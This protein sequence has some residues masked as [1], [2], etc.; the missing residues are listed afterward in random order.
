MAPS[1]SP[2][3]VDG[4]ARAHT[5]IRSV[6]EPR[7]DQIKHHE[8]RQQHAVQTE[9]LHPGIGRREPN[10]ARVRRAPRPS[11]PTRQVLWVIMTWNK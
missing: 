4:V 7:M 11:W 8:E 6:P 3:I 9:E 1:S 2:I 10:G 5:A